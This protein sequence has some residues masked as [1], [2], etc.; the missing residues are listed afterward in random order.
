MVGGKET[1]AVEELRELRGKLSTSEAKSKILEENV[2]RLNEKA[3]AAITAK[4]D[5]QKKLETSVQEQARLKLD[6]DMR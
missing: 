4:K 2:T 3:E 1:G 6:L 5:I